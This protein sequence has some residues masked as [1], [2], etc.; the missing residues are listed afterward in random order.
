MDGSRRVAHVYSV[1]E[2]GY[3]WQSVDF[4]PNMPRYRPM[5]EDEVRAQCITSVRAKMLMRQIHEPAPD[6]SP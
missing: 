5:P 2:G 3:S 6:E 1:P 4:T